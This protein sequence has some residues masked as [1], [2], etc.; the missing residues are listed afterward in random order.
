MVHSFDRSPFQIHSLCELLR[1]IHE[2]HWIT[3]KHD[4][5]ISS[6]FWWLVLT[7]LFNKIDCIRFVHYTA[8][9]YGSFIWKE[10]A[11]FILWTCT[12][13]AW[14]SIT[15]IN[16]NWLPI[17]SSDS[18]K[19]SLLFHFSLPSITVCRFSI[20]LLH[21]L[22][23]HWAGMRYKQ[24]ANTKYTQTLSISDQK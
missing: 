9:M 18:M 13:H 10:R 20:F 14:S 7:H 12:F 3:N 19:Y 23:T 2:N 21:R 8:C 1:K 22:Q 6:C 17:Q 11:A 15:S 5:G 24:H 16:K 4:K